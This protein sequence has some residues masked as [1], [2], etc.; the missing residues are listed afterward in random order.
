MMALQEMTANHFGTNYLRKL[1]PAL[2]INH[3]DQ[4]PPTQIVFMRR[5]W[6]AK[7]VC[8]GGGGT[9]IYFCNLN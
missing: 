1:A 3:R 7:F 4:Q 9:C 6:R 5:V 2:P 8:V